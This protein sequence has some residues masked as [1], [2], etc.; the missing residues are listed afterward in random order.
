ML[1][2]S[3]TKAIYYLSGVFL[4]STTTCCGVEGVVTKCGLYEPWRLGWKIKDRIKN[5]STQCWRCSQ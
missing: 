3:P 4:F 2:A 1:P 5:F